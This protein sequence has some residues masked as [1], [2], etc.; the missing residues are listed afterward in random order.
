MTTHWAQMVVNY[1]T[2]HEINVVK[3]APYASD[4]VRAIRIR[5]RVKNEI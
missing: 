5:V 2:E 1:V 4:I 3:Q